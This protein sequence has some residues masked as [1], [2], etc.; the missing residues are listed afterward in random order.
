MWLSREGFWRIYDAIHFCMM[1]IIGEY[2]IMAFPKIVINVITIFLGTRVWHILVKLL[3]WCRSA[4]FLE[5]CR[6]VFQN[7]YM[8]VEEIYWYRALYLV[9]DFQFPFTCHSQ[10]KEIPLPKMFKNLPL[11][12][13]FFKVSDTW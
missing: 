1:M 11:F 2:S 5:F 3:G 10:T 13:S 7:K 9:I 4:H 12:C 8:N 6:H